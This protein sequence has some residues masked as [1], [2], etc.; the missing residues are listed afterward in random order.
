VLGA[1]IHGEEKGGA[2]PRPLSDEENSGDDGG[3]LA[4]AKL[5]QEEEEEPPRP[6]PPRS[7]GAAAGAPAAC[8]GSHRCSGL[9]WT[10]QN[11][12]RNYQNIFNFNNN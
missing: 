7:S 2:I 5:F 4:C 11:K 3:W 8:D 9:R 12:P 1:G 10:Y 6:A